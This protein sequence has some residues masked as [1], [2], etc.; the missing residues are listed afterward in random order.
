VRRRAQQSGGWPLVAAT[1]RQ[2]SLSLSL[3]LCLARRTPGAVLT[4]KRLPFSSTVLHF[5]FLACGRVPEQ[6]A[7]TTS[8]SYVCLRRVLDH[9]Y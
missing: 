3:A 6:H 1:A 4:K 7:S 2:P 5:P 8:D 9:T